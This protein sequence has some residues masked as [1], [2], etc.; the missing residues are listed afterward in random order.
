MVLPEICNWVR[1]SP[2]C[3]SDEDRVGLHLLESPS[4]FNHTARDPA[5][6]S[7]H[8]EQGLEPLWVLPG[9]QRSPPSLKPQQPQRW[10]L[11]AVCHLGGLSFQPGVSLNSLTYVLAA[12][13]SAHLQHQG[14]RRTKASRRTAKANGPA[15]PRQNLP[16]FLCRREIRVMQRFVQ[17]SHWHVL[18]LF[19]RNSR[20]WGANAWHPKL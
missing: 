1:Y 20:K 12:V 16:R 2:G 6:S 10:R 15:P 13:T 14:E 5:G 8:R 19:S 18:M 17:N 3:W 4:A 7:M 11:W 9:A